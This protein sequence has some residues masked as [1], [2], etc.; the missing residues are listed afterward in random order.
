MAIL[1]ISSQT[2][3]LGFARLFPFVDTKMAASSLLI[4]VCGPQRKSFSMSSTNGD[5]IYHNCI[6]GL[7]ITKAPF[8]YT[9]S[10]ARA[11]TSP[12]DNVMSLHY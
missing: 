5:L 3:M 6:V 8:R 9:S 10:K 7:G 4:S 12:A 11:L 2:W 1:E